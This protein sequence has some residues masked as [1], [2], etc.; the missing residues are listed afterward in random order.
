MIYHKF[1]ELKNI[2]IS[3]SLYLFLSHVSLFFFFFPSSSSSSPPSHRLN[4]PNQKTLHRPLLPLSSSQNST[5]S[6]WRCI[7]K[8]EGIVPLAPSSSPTTSCEEF[9]R[10]WLFLVLW[11]DAKYRAMIFWW[12]MTWIFYGDLIRVDGRELICWV[13]FFFFWV[14]EEVDGTSRKTTRWKGLCKRERGTILIEKKKKLWLGRPKDFNDRSNM[15]QFHCNLSLIDLLRLLR[16]NP[17]TNICS[18]P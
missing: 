15:N 14:L 17:T 10:G 8:K 6:N 9:C 18:A 12:G 3:L 7:S 5:P 1:S 4:L 13:F 2:F 16:L 11:R